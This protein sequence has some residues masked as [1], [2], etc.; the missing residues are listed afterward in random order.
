MQLQ[1]LTASTRVSGTKGKVRQ[2]RVQGNVP[3]VL[4][5]GGKDPVTLSF[6]ARDFVKL[7][8]A[9]GAHAIVQLEVGDDAAASSPALL[10]EVQYHPVRG[11][12]VHADFQRIRLDE[13]ITTLVPVHFSGQAKGLVDGGVLDYQLR[14]LEIECLALEVPEHIE[15][16]VSG[17]GIGDHLYVSAVV[18]PEGV[19]ILTES[20]R[21][22]IACHA[23]R[24]TKEDSAAAEAAADAAAAA[25]AALSQPSK[26]RLSR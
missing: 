9:G 22:V 1:S 10:R 19:T 23:P 4:Y 16:D 20:D 11:H 8:H 25:P 12:I 7:V 13:R 24:A 26:A 6:N 21:S 14:E 5:G 3:G 18:A 2:N 17:L 15:L